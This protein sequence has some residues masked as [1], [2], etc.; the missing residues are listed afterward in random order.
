MAPIAPRSGD[1]IFANIER[2][3]SKLNPNTHYTMFGTQEN[4]IAQ[5]ST[6]PQFYTNKLLIPPFFSFA[7]EEKCHF[8]LKFVESFIEFIVL[9]CIRI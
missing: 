6:S 8:C 5:L 1:A 3:V 2:V 4:N 9:I 7:L